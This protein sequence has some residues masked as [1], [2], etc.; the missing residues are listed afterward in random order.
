MML[1]Y[2]YKIKPFHEKWENYLS[3]FNEA[4]VYI[5]ILHIYLL[6]YSEGFEDSLDFSNKVGWSYVLLIFI[7]VGVNLLTRLIVM[8]KTVFLMIKQVL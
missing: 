2:L 7:K 8:V 4:M 3:L 6:K 5:G 1:I